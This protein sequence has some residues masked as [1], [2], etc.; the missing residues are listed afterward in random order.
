MQTLM[1]N[2]TIE[3]ATAISI[4]DTQKKHWSCNMSHC[5]LNS[6]IWFSSF[7][8]LRLYGRSSWFLVHIQYP[9]NNVYINDEPALSIWLGFPFSYRHQTLATDLRHL[10]P[11]HSATKKN[12][13]SSLICQCCRHC[14][15]SLLYTGILV[16]NDGPRHQK[17]SLFLFFGKNITHK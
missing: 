12:F 17:Y 1:G 3:H 9:H 2:T 6:L 4:I 10:Q 11:T 15:C 8:T 7:H 5:L 16:H 13:I 14:W